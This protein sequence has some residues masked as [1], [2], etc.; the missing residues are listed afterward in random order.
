MEKDESCR[1][2]KREIT[3]AYNDSGYREENILLIDR[4][5]GY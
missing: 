1:N 3:V 4:T 2:V 5:T